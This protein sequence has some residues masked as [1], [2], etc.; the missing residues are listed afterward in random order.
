MPMSAEAPR[1][2]NYEALD[3]ELGKLPGRVN[4]GVFRISGPADQPEIAGASPNALF[5]LLA[6]GTAIPPHV[7][8]NNTRLVCHLP[9]VVPDGCWF[10]V[11][12]ET[13]DWE[14]GQAFVFDDTIEHEAMNP[15]EQLR[16]VFIFDL[17]H[18]DLRPAERAAVAAMIGSAPDAVPESL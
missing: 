2:A 13:R 9:L 10:R 7:G 15:S 12:A 4:C 5:S 17:W 14:R 1:L 18:P 16:V 3:A 6:P 8:Y 11:G